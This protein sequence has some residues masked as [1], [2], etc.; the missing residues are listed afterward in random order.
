MLFP[1][2]PAWSVPDSRRTPFPPVFAGEDVP[3][4]VIQDISQ[5]HH[6]GHLEGGGMTIEYAG[7]EERALAT[8]Q[9]SLS[10]KSYLFPSVACGS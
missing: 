7:L 10:Q 2:P 3:D 5:V 9:F 4:G 8:E 6:A 1:L